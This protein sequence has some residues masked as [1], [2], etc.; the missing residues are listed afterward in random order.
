[1]LSAISRRN[2]VLHCAAC[3]NVR[4][5]TKRVLLRPAIDALAI[6]AI[7]QIGSALWSISATAVRM[8]P[9]TPHDPPLYPRLVQRERKKQFIPV[10]QSA[11]AAKGGS[12]GPLTDS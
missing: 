7:P 6:M 3:S 10:G 5:G 11:I 2:A 12:G 4:G 8:T 9:P 1:M